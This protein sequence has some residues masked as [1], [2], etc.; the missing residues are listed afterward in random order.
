MLSFNLG[1]ECIV[2]NKIYKKYFYVGVL[3]KSPAIQTFLQLLYVSVLA[4][5][6]LLHP[7]QLPNQGGCAV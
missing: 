2:Q 1:I 6:Q 7:T 4:S 5:R 3:P